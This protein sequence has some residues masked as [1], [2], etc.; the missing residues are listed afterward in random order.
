MVAADPSITGVA[1]ASI[2][3]RKHRATACPTES[4]PIH[5]PTGSNHLCSGL[6]H[7]SGATADTC[8]VL[9]GDPA[10]RT[11]SA[12]LGRTFRY[13]RQTTR[14]L[15]TFRLLVTTLHACVWRPRTCSMREAEPFP[16]SRHR[17]IDKCPK[18]ERY[19]ALARV[20]QVDRCRQRFESFQKHHEATGF[21]QF[22]NLVRRYSCNASRLRRGNDGSLHRVHHKPGR[23]LYLQ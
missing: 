21:H 22:F 7:C 19:L 11:T 17:K 2:V 13:A 16:Q 12:G 15:E 3:W 20:H 8:S 4:R 5:A 23:D 6:G 18:L 1:Y 14:L 10:W 9:N